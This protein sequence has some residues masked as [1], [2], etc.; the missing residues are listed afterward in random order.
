[1]RGICAVLLC[2]LAWVS[3]ARAQD[4]CLE[5]ASTLP[6]QRD[7]AALR[8][9]LEA[10]C[11][12][13]S[14]TA[15]SA[16][17]RC[18]KTAIDTALTAGDLRPQCEEAARA[19]RR[20]ATCGS[21]KIACGRFKPSADHPLS[22]RVKPASRCADGNRYEQNAC[23]AQTHCADVIDWTATTCV[24][25]R[26]RTPFEAGVKVLTFT[27]D[28]VVSPGNPRVLDTVVWYP[29][30]RGA[31]PISSFYEAVL[32]APLDLSGAPYPVLLFSHGSCGF[33]AQSTFLTALLAGQGFIVV[34]PPH[35]GNTVFDFPNCGTAQALANSFVERPPDMVFVLDEMLAENADPLSP[36]FA[37][38]DENKV[39]M[40]GHS[41][42]G[43]TTYL[44]ES[45]D[46]RIKVALPMAAA[47]PGAPTLQVPSLTLLGQ[48]DSVVNNN[49]IRTA[50]MN[51]Q[52]PKYLIEIANA[53]HYAFSNGCFPSSDCNPPVTLTQVEAH[54][55]VLR[56]VLP[57]LERHLVGDESFAP[58]FSVAPPGV[59]FAS[60]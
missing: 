52:P 39:G 15:R 60:D 57:F 5:G 38:L 56:W 2:G 16:F 46:A 50:Y 19:L 20:G 21:A 28:S 17:Q 14:F 31:T 37:A 47:V 54:A 40:S 6:D 26:T 27:K 11:P 55:A 10:A 43:L 35:P 1:M 23:T 18:A 9:A 51:A 24:D 58:F 48:I 8:A 25:V 13:A 59:V 32:D 4:A 44:V 49:S 12:C 7:L 30:T 34:A 36:F 41:F 3:T 45:Q 22:C 33:P 29:T 42:G 53:G